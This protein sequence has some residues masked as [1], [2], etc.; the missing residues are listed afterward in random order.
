M[1]ELIVALDVDTINEEEAILKELK[2]NVTF[3][4]IGL[5]LFTAHG[6]RAVDLVHRFGGRVFLDLKFHDIPFTVEEAA[7]EAGRM[8]V[9]LFNVHAAGGS[10]MMKAAVKGAEKGAR[11]IGQARPKIIAVTVLTSLT[12]SDLAQIGYAENAD[13]LTVRLARLALDS[14][15]D[16]VVAS[17]KEAALL[18]KQLGE[19]FLIVSPGIRFEPGKDDQKRVSGPAEAIKAGADYLVVGRPIRDAEDP[20]Q[21][22]QLIRKEIEDAAR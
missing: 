20:A 18:R 10:E 19:N 15:L 16:G 13:K 21:A 7:Y 11:E 14:G 5:R 9:W 2:D 6:K 1:T 12:D 4:K 3:Y 8:G 22:A 17:P